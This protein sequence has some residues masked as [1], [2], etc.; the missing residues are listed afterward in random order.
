MKNTLGAR[1]ALL[2]VLAAATLYTLGCGV[3]TGAPA[4]TAQNTYLYVGA[5]FAP[6]NRPVSPNRLCDPVPSRS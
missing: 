3:S 2:I 4:A 5:G 1:A 6:P